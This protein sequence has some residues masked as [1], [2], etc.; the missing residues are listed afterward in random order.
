[1][2]ERSQPP[3]WEQISKVVGSIPSSPCQQFFNPGLLNKAP[4]VSV[5]VIFSDHIDFFSRTLIKGVDC[6]LTPNESILH[7]I[8]II[9]DHLLSSLTK[10]IKIIVEE[11]LKKSKFFRCKSWKTYFWV[12]LTYYYGCKNCIDDLSIGIWQPVSH[13]YIHQLKPGFRYS[14][15]CS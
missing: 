8:I 14:H 15:E 7:K 13:I 1:V 9:K 6:T 12:P 3:N 10:K 4:S 11:Q 5:M 2:A